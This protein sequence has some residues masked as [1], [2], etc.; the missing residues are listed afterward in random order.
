MATMELPYLAQGPLAEAFAEQTGDFAF[1]YDRGTFAAWVGTR[2]S[3]GD[4]ENLLL[5]RA[6]NSYLGGLFPL[7]PL[8]A[9]TKKCCSIPDSAKG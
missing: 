5:K 2:W 7:Y 9:H 3:I 4:P 6:V 8:P 1:L